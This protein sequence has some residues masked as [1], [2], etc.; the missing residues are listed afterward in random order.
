MAVREGTELKPRANRR[1]RTALVLVCVTLLAACS[2]GG[3]HVQE[4]GGQAVDP[5][6]VDF[7]IFYIKRYAIPTNQDDLRMMRQAVL[8]ATPPCAD[9]YMRTQ[10]A[11][12][13]TE[14]N[15]TQRITG[16]G[17]AK[18]ASYDVKDV[19]V[20]TDGKTILFAMRG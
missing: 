3:G 20:S 11:P 6:T 8:C 12:D 17:T 13:G 15:V 10:A 7:P 9:L 14:L 4:A 5:A 16:T 1:A 2:S 19:T 18:A